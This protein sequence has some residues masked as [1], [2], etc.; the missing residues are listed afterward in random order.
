M[1]IIWDFSANLGLFY[2][3]WSGLTVQQNK[4]APTFSFM[5]LEMKT[6]WTHTLLEPHI[7]KLDTYFA[8]IF[9]DFAHFCHLFSKLWPMCTRAATAH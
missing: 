5:E 1:Q 2:L 8:F 7:K 9:L 6:A 4:T 3:N